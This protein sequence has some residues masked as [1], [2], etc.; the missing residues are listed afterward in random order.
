MVLFGIEKMTI[1]RELNIIYTKIPY[2]PRIRVF[3]LTHTVPPWYPGIWYLEY[4]LCIRIQSIRGSIS[5][6]ALRAQSRLSAVSN[7]RR[8]RN[9]RWVQT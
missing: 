1:R 9:V 5:G 8:L 2:T 6:T 4:G 3:S 7:L